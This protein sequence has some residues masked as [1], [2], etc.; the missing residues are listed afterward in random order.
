VAGRAFRLAA[1]GSHPVPKLY[2]AARPDA[3]RVTTEID[4]TAYLPAKRAAMRA[5]ATQLTLL[6]DESFALSNGIRQTL[7]G[8]EYYTLLAGPGG[9]GQGGREQDLFAGIG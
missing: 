1:A 9:A 7:R 8:R 4:A 3:A 6:D 5:H 2:A